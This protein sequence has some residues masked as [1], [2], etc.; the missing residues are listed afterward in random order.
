MRAIVLGLAA[1]RLSAAER[2]FFQAVAPAGFILFKRNCQAPEQLR[3]LTGELRD[4]LGWAAP[5]LI[6]QE[7]GRVQRLAPPVWTARPAPGV[8][9]AMAEEDLATAT[10]AAFLNAALMAAELSSL[11]I[12]VNCVPNLDLAHP[13]AAPAVV[14]DRS[15][16]D[17]PARV[18]ALGRAVAEGT[19]A[20]GALPVI[21]HLPGHGRGA[22]D[23]HFALPQ[24]DAAPAV[25]EA[26]DFLPFQTLADLPLAMTGHLLMSAYDTARPATTSPTVIERVIRGWMGFDGLL[27]SDDLSMQALVGDVGAR[28]AACLA[29]GCDVA[30]HC[31]GDMDEMAAVADQTRD[32]DAAGRRRFDAA[33]ARRP[34]AASVDV[35]AAAAELADLMPVASTA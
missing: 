15:Y 18:A 23:S 33:L 31:N 21:K 30:L 9:R 2:R 12:D 1:E 8:F 35:A 19:M 28:A 14:G 4:C 3:A 22:V 25:L 10:R 26:S 5:I 34:A 13:E 7:G 6:D 29:A 20:G 27:M 16:G 32:F 24:V 17:D 11:G